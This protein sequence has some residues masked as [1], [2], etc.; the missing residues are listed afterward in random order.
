M[1]DVSLCS[2]PY[3]DNTALWNFFRQGCKKKHFHGKESLRNVLSGSKQQV[4]PVDNGIEEEMV[5]VLPRLRR[6]AYSLT[7][8]WA[9]ADDLVQATCMRAIERLDQWEVGSRLDSWMYRIAQNL[10]FNSVRKDRTRR[11][12]LRAV[13][14]T[15]MDVAAQNKPVDRLVLADLDTAIERL[16]ADQ[17]SVLLLIAVEGRSYDEVSDILGISSGT[18]A[19][20]LSRARATLAVMLEGEQ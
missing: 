3:P 14:S 8:G 7:G 12:H 20:R 4:C 11:A 10:H 5:A 19:S 18:V 13:G 1:A 17:R 2:S 15:D 16:P 6:F 9:D